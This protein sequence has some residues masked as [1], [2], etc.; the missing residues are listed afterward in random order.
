MFTEYQAWKFLAEEFHQAYT[1][2]T[3][4]EYTPLGLCY[5]IGRLSG[6]IKR[7]SDARKMAKAK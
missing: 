2:K 7:K 5:S 3:S 6:S 4:K 1:T